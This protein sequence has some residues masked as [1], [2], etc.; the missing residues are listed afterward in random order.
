[1][2]GALQL[3]VEFLVEY[4]VRSL[5]EPWQ[6]RSEAN[7]FLAGLGVLSAGAAAGVITSLV[8]PTRI[9][10]PG[11]I[12]GLSLL[13]TPLIS[14]VVMERYGQWLDSRGKPRTFLATFWGGALFA[15]GMALV[16]FLWV[17]R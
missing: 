9:I 5:A 11:P 12:P 10:G 7:P 4:G 14:G 17:G 13:F 6:R 3:A 1:M 2:E 8:W 16:R 15:F